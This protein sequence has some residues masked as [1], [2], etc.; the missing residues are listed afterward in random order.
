MGARDDHAERAS[1]VENSAYIGD[2]DGEYCA[3]GGLIYSASFCFTANANV[4]ANTTQRR[5]VP[6]RYGNRPFVILLKRPA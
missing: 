3:T 4:H 2:T 5:R 6:H 1:G